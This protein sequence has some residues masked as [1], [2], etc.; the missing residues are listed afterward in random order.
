MLK[1]PPYRCV[2]GEMFWRRPILPGTSDI[3]QLDKIW[4]LCGTPNQHTWPN[5]D[6]L[7]GCE[8]VKQFQQYPRRVKV[9]YET[10]VSSSPPLT[11]LHAP[12]SIGPETVDLLDKLLTCN[13]RERITAAEALDHDYFWS[14]PLPADPKT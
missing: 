6:Q 9:F 13:P 1:F 14:D 3:D 5:Y 4:A 2:L 12:P 8:G 11:S 10:C 7:P